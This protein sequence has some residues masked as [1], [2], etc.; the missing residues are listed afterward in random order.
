MEIER[1]LTDHELSQSAMK[2]AQQFVQRWDLHARQLDDGRYIC[3]HKSLNAGHLIAHLRGEITLGS[4]LLN[5]KS[6]AR[7]LVF[8]ADDE[9]GISDLVSLAQNLDNEDIPTY[10]EASRRGGHLW[11]FFGQAISGLRVR[12]FGGGLLSSHGINGI[13]LFPKQDQLAVGP[14]SLIRIPFG[15]HRRDGQRYSFI[16]LEGEPLAPTISQQIRVLSTPQFVPEAVFDANR[17]YA[18]VHEKTVPQKTV[19]SPGETVSARIKNRVS[20]LEFIC[21]FVDLQPSG[22]GAIGLCPFHE[23]LNPSLSVNAQDNYWHCFAGCGGGSIID[24]WMLWTDSD[25]KETI[26]E[27][28]HILGI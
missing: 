26:V 28:A 17:A 27:L 10:L 19:E 7:F 4:Y 9:N 20:V 23:D 15:V 11:F 25:F 21:Q 6:E 24:F 12:E 16:T 14:G 22:L 8:D 2:L 13:E 1:R 18:S 5:P 3:I